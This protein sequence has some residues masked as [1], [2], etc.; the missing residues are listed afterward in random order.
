[1]VRR[2]RKRRSPGM[3]EELLN[4]ARARVKIPQPEDDAH[5]EARS[6]RTQ[7]FEAKLACEP[8]SNRGS[9]T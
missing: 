9:E 1:M 2:C 6:I 4:G 8:A 5:D 7:T 3:V